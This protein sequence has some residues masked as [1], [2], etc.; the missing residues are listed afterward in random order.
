MV[1]RRPSGTVR[2]LSDSL[3]RHGPLHGSR[4]RRPLQ[5]QHHLSQPLRPPSRRQE[6][7]ARQRQLV[8]R[9]HRR[10]RVGN[11]SLTWPESV[12]PKG[13]ISLTRNQFQVGMQIILMIPIIDNYLLL[14]ANYKAA[15]S[16]TCLC[17]NSVLMKVFL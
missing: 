13:N 7:R 10:Y 16:F 3:P 5:Q 2:A 12:E 11:F 1:V 9:L 4:L 17:R 14:T 15:D 6:P 8:L